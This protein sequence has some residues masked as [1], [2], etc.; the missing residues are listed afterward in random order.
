MMDDMFAVLDLS[1]CHD[2]QASMTWVT[3]CYNRLDYKVIA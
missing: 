1:R 2:F 3:V